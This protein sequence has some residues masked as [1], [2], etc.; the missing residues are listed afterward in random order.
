MQNMKI[1]K[2]SVPSGTTSKPVHEHGLRATPAGTAFLAQ[3]RTHSIAPSKQ[4]SSKKREGGKMGL[5]IPKPTVSKIF[6]AVAEPVPTSTGVVGLVSGLVGSL[7]HH[8]SHANVYQALSESLTHID[9]L[10]RT[11]TT[12]GVGREGASRAAHV[13][14][15]IKLAETN[16]HTRAETTTLFV[17]PSIRPVQISPATN[18]GEGMVVLGVGTG[19]PAG[20]QM[21]SRA[22]GVEVT[23]DKQPNSGGAA[24]TIGEQ[25]L[26][27][28]SETAAAARRKR[29]T[30][31]AVP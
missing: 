29:Y 31:L 9:K 27:A 16:T 7:V 6:V 2:N 8:L 28:R 25:A 5:E 20:K 1:S 13:A 14:T 24:R 4:K 22:E 15:P 30:M 12:E 19:V 10:V 17:A 11:S 26:D 21:S 23:P 3:E 18:Q